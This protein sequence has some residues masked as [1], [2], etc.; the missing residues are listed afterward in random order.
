MTH[1]PMALPVTPVPPLLPVALRNAA[2]RRGGRRRLSMDHLAAAPQA[3]HQN[4]PVI[5]GRRRDPRR[6]RGR[7]SPLPKL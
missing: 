3:P 7:P 5:R 1:H 4:H 6:T 2:R